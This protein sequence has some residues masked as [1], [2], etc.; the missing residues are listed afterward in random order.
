MEN[1]M[2]T[3]NPSSPDQG[4]RRVD[5]GSVTGG[6]VLIVVGLLFL[7]ERLLPDFRFGDYW[8]LILVVLG[9]G[10]VWKSWRPQ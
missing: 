1:I 4:G 9:I 2:D 10:L 5:R 7:G 3:T 8:P 6:I